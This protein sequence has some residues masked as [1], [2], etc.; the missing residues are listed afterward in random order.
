MGTLI[1]ENVMSEDCVIEKQVKTFLDIVVLAILNG[2]S[3][4]GYKIIAAIHRDFGILLSPASIY[5]LLHLLEN[6]KLIESRPDKGKTVY[7][8]TPKGKEKF[9]KI[10]AAY[11]LSIQIITNFIK[12]REK[13]F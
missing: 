8:V 12:T 4:Y 11:N 7:C 6:N 1:G 10:F 9:E 3:M 2:N 13:F 5:P